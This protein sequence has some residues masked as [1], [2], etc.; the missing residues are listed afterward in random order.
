M[1]IFLALGYNYIILGGGHDT[2]SYGLIRYFLTFSF[3]EGDIAR[4][5]DCHTRDKRL[6]EGHIDLA[7]NMYRQPL[8]CKSLCKVSNLDI[9]VFLKY[10]SIT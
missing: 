6:I 3:N 5:A 2:I 10:K 8:W 9:D 7:Q 4:A 1:C